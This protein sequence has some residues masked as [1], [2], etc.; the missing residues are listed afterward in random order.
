M[1]MRIFKLILIM[2]LIPN[3]LFAKTEYF[4]EGVNLY[5]NNF[6]SIFMMIHY[7]PVHARN[8]IEYYKYI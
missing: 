2:I 5:K 4:D 1:I 6:R 8:S 3:I 7:I